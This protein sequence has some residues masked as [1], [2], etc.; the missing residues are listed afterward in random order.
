M[1][2]G[3][4]SSSTLQGLPLLEPDQK[5]LFSLGRGNCGGGIRCEGASAASSAFGPDANAEDNEANNVPSASGRMETVRH[6]S[7]L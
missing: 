4:S 7:P 3:I 1:R 2:T 5:G 6:L